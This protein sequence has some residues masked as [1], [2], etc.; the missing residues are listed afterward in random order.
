MLLT[1]STRWRTIGWPPTRSNSRTTAIGPREQGSWSAG[2]RLES[3]VCELHFLLAP[4]GFFV[5]ARSL[6]LPFFSLLL[7]LRTGAQLSSTIR[8]PDCKATAASFSRTELRDGVF[9][10]YKSPLVFSAYLVNSLYSWCVFY[11]FVCVEAVSNCVK[12]C[13]NTL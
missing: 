10:T 5:Q 7:R 12:N 1:V 6:L 13:L 11:A 4:P 2:K 3:P 9:V 8:K